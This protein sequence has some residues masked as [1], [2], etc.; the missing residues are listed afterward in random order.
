[1]IKGILKKIIF[2]IMYHSLNS[3]CKEQN[4]HKINDELKKIGSSP[5]K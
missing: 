2:K 1:M 5:L 3:A 4:L